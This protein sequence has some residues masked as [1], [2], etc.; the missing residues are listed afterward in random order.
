MIILP[1]IL[2]YVFEILYFYTAKKRKI[3]AQPLARVC[4]DKKK[5]ETKDGRL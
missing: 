1:N 2:K 3:L 4:K 5:K